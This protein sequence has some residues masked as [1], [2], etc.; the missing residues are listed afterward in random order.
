MYL[1]EWSTLNE[2]AIWLSETK[3]EIWTWKTV[4]QKFAELNPITIRVVIP[5]DTII[6][7][8]RSGIVQETSFRSPKSLNV[9]RIEKFLI[10]MLEGDDFYNASTYSI[11]LMDPTGDSRFHLNSP[12]QSKAIRLSREQVLNLAEIPPLIAFDSLVKEIE[13]GY[14]P[15]LKNVL[16]EKSFVG[17][18]KNQ[19]RERVEPTH[20]LCSTEQ[21]WKVRKVDR[22]PGYRKPLYDFIKSEHKAG[23]PPPTAR[24]VFEQW[25]QTPP[26]EIIKVMARDLEYWGPNETIKSINLRGI[27]KTIARIV[28]LG[29]SN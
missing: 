21:N 4:L 2:A 23:N 13:L 29:E 9:C 10:D 1:Q 16:E 5:V 20:S 22:F 17:L 19:D 24:K 6:S 3:D 11:E 27:T 14:F 12:I 28:I 18:S 7:E 15:E 8:I 25:R 26:A